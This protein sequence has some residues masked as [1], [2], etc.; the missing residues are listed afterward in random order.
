MKS[1]AFPNDPSLPFFKWVRACDI[2]GL[3]KKIVCPEERFNKNSS[4]TQQNTKNRSFLND[5]G[6]LP[7]ISVYRTPGV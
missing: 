6:R 7:Y 1:F 2:C 4:L 3:V 5:T